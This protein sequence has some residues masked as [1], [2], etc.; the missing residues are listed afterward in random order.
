[1][2]MHTRT[3]AHT[4]MSPLPV[5]FGPYNNQPLCPSHPGGAGVTCSTP[6]PMSPCQAPPCGPAALPGASGGSSWGHPCFGVARGHH[7]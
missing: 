4:H 5:A 7:G 2:H 3:H 6:V 1:M